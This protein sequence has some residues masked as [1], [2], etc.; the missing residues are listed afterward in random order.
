MPF[1][2]WNYKQSQPLLTSPP[3]RSRL[4]TGDILR[5]PPF[6]GLQVWR[7][8]EVHKLGL[9]VNN[10]FNLCFNSYHSMED[11]K[12]WWALMTLMINVIIYIESVHINNLPQISWYNKG[13]VLQVQVL[14]N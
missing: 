4:Q 14:A 3:A 6:K 13:Y 2:P 10:G 11:L 12:R 1:T 9:D 7:G 8:G 5:Q